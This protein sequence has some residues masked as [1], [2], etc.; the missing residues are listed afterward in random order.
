MTVNKTM[1]RSSDGKE[2]SRKAVYDETGCLLGEPVPTK[3]SY[4]QS[5]T[6]AANTV[7][8][9]RKSDQRRNASAFIHE[10]SKVPD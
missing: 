2:N 8:D 4:T 7:G 10:S 1:S 5:T 6:I 3:A 9:R